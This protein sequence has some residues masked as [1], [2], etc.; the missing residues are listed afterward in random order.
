M[1]D[2]LS[3]TEA[4]TMPRA[5]AGGSVCPRTAPEVY[6]TDDGKVVVKDELLNFGN[7]MEMIA[8]DGGRR[9]FTGLKA[10][11]MYKMLTDW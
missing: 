10:M 5:V 2:H 1:H 6:R 4:S 9:T 7:G 3:T 8:T 11:K